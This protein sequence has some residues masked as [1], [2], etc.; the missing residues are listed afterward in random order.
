MTAQQ[1]EPRAAGMWSPDPIRQRLADCT[2]EDVPCLPVEAVPPVTRRR[3][4]P[5]KPF[6]IRLPIRDTAP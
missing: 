3:D 5:E 4:R 2:V 6:Q 1:A